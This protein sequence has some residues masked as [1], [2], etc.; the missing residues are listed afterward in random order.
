M[1]LAN[2]PTDDEHPY[3]HSQLECIGALVVGSVVITMAVVIFWDAVNTIYE[4]SIG[5]I[6]YLGSPRWLC[7]QHYLPCYSKSF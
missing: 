4:L 3:G 5:E 1:R 2:K 7:G 6:S